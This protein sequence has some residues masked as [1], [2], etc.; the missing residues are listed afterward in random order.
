MEG[1][2]ETAKEGSS[3]GARR[4]SCARG[5]GATVQRPHQLVGQEETRQVP[6]DARRN[7]E[8]RIDFRLEER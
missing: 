8:S 2:Q 1:S 6:R 3:L 5:E 7:Y 4:Q